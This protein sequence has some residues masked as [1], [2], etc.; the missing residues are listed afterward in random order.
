MKPD[1]II[2]EGLVGSRAYGLDTEHSDHDIKGVFV[3]P[4][5]KI[6][7]LYK[8]KEAIDNNQRDRTIN[9]DEDDWAYYEIE[10]FLRMAMQCNPSVLELLYLDGYLTQTKFGKMLVDNRHLFLNNTARK[11]YTGYVFSQAMKLNAQ[12]GKYGGGKNNRYE[13]HTRHLFRLLQQ[14][15][16]LLTTGTVTVRVTNRDE[17]FAYGKLTPNEVI[18]LFTEKIAEFKGLDSVLP[19]K[20]NKA[21]INK[22]LLRIRK[23][24]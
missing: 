16:E 2:L 10:K 3:A 15:R 12:G 5:Q 7:S 22:L 19:D 6:L 17:L 24:N 11:S 9:P 14:G 1:N 23:G 13:K 4:T 8:V 20:P 18:N 21:E